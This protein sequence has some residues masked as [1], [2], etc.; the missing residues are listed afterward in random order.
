MGGWVFVSIT[1]SGY[2]CLGAGH[3]EVI[4]MRGNSAVSARSLRSVYCMC[5]VFDKSDSYT[6]SRGFVFGGLGL[7]V[8]WLGCWMAE[9]RDNVSRGV[10]RA[11]VPSCTAQHATALTRAL[12]GLWT[13]WSP[14]SL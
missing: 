1:Q 8:G 4:V 13:L 9:V 12:Q 14:R 2:K 10:L 7:V 3:V 6:R 5:V 11:Y